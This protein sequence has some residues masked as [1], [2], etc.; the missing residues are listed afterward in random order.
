MEFSILYTGS[1]ELLEGVSHNVDD[2]PFVTLIYRHFMADT[3]VCAE[4]VHIYRLSL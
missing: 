2:F 1:K 3:D 4:I